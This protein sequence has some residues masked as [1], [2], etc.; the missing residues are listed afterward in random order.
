MKGKP[1]SE[2]RQL[3]NAELERLL[4]D[5]KAQL[6]RLRFQKALGELQDT[7]AIKATKREIA[8]IK[9]ILRERELAKQQQVGAT[10]GKGS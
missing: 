6:M 7:S 4:Q 9:T 5:D 8:R 2:L 3:T 1:A 10:K